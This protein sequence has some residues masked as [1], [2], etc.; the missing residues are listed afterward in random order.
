MR[1][2][3]EPC[4][5]CCNCLCCSRIFSGEK[6]S[7]GKLSVR[8]VLGGGMGGWSSREVGAGGHMR[9]PCEARNKWSQGRNVDEWAPV[10]SVGRATGRA[11]AEAVTCAG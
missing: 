2:R 11:S 7:A 4:L 9:R 8:V 1:T 5:V 6:V 10:N 3:A